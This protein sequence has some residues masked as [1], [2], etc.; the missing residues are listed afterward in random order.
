MTLHT[1]LGIWT[2]YNVRIRYPYKTADKQTK[3][4]D[5]E[6]LST[7]TETHIIFYTS[8]SVSELSKQR[9]S[10]FVGSIN[11][12]MTSCHVEVVTTACKPYH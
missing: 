1:G 10:Q 12:L 8:T 4:P 11:P 2:I 9:P 5:T 3:C 6:N 7:D